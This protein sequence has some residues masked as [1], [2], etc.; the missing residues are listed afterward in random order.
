MAVGLGNPGRRYADT[1]HNVGFMIIDEVVRRHGVTDTGLRKGAW[2]GRSRIDSRDV[3]LV[4]P[5]TFMN[6]SGEAVAQLWRWYKLD[7]NDILV[8][9]DDIDLPF[10]R[11][12]LRSGGSAG[13]HNGLRSIISHLGSPDVA[14][15]RIGIG[16]PDAGAAREYVLD[17]FNSDERVD[18]PLVIAKG[19][20]AVEKW[21]SDGVV[22]TMNQVNALSPSDTGPDSVSPTESNPR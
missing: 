11:L 12:R 10:G 21:V 15:L 20:D 18:L 7:L 1:R 8:V 22:A 6:L 4:K 9:S 16:R 19:A 17:T 5:Q 13:G 2:V 3:V 14:R